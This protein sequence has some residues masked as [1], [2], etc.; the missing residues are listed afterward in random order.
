MDATHTITLTIEL[1][2]TMERGRHPT[3]LVTA[4]EYYVER[5][6]THLGN[7]DDRRQWSTLYDTRGAPVAELTALLN[8]TG[9]A[10]ARAD[11][12]T[13]LQYLSAVIET[14]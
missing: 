14:D 9:I 12:E 2:L 11:G 6:N 3:D 13:L 5:I 1:P 10:V 7:D 8:L 4:A